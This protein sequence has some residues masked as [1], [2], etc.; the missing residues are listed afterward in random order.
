MS[1]VTNLSPGD[2]A[3]VNDPFGSASAALSEQEFVTRHAGRFLCVLMNDDN[4]EDTPAFATL[5]GRPPLQNAG[6]TLCV[7]PVA[8]RTAAN[9]FSK[10]I[11]FGRAPNNDLRIELAE[12]SKFHGYFAQTGEEWHVTD[13]G[14][15]N[16]T[17]LD[18]LRLREREPVA[19]RPGANLNLGA[20]PGVYVDGPGLYHLLRAKE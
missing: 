2:W 17:F 16:G 8:K 7:F 9:P 10:M 11:T 5:E 3:S 19:I 12:V 6:Q 4:A 15:T 1:D 20:A 14:S 18:G 13:A